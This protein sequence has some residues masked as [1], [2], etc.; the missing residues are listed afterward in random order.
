MDSCEENAPPGP[1][2]AIGELGIEDLP[3]IA[4][5]TITVAESECKELGKISGIVDTLGNIF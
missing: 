5:L 4:E 2:K 3:P 1:I